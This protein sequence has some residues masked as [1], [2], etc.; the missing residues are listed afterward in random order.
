[1]VSRRGSGAVDVAV[2]SRPVAVQEGMATVPIRLAFK[3]AAHYPVGTPLQIEIEAETHDKVVLV[4]SS[5]LV[6][7]G[8]EAAV[9]VAAGDKAQRRPVTVGLDDDEHAEIS[10]A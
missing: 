2:V 7:E 5:A 6:R 9:F 10:A 8:E 4:P 1:M 3:A